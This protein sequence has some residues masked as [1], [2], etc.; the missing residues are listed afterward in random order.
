MQPPAHRAGPVITLVSFNHRVD[1]PLLVLGPALGTA[2]RPLWQVVAA[3]LD[4]EFHVVGWD[5][6]GHGANNHPVPATSSVEELTQA[7]LAALGPVFAE[8]NAGGGH[9]HYAGCGIGGVVGLQLALTIRERVDSLVVSGMGAVGTNET[10]WV[11]NAG[12]A[13]TSDLDAVP[14]SL[15]AGVVGPGFLE[16]HQ[17]TAEALIQAFRDL[18]PAG[19]RLTLGALSEV[20]LRADLPRLVPPLLVLSGGED[21]ITPPAMAR[22]LATDVPRGSAAELDGV[23]H[24]APAEDPAAVAELLRQ[25]TSPE[26]GAPTTTELDREWKRVLAAGGAAFESIA[27]RQSPFDLMARPGLEEQTRHALVIGALAT[28]GRLPE[29]ADQV[30]AARSA[31]VGI[32]TIGETLLVVATYGGIPAARRAADVVFCILAVEVHR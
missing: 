22:E 24:L 3:H 7:L 8:R 9:L 32:G 15:L 13:S 27:S 5:L 23:G 14:D 31:G 4:E 20:D 16:E 21:Q 29:L 25:H 18:D 17:D 1:R 26:E 2:V 12:L 10:L 6:P 30:R 11:E 19:I 28:A